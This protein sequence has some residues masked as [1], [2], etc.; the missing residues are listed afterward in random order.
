MPLLE[1]GTGG[2]TE[3]DPWIPWM[4]LGNL[5]NDDNMQLYVSEKEWPVYKY[6]LQV[7]QLL[8][9]SHHGS[10]DVKDLVTHLIPQVMKEYEK[11]YN[12]VFG[13]K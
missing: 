11:A 1:Y 9:L 8:W 13:K 7:G 10:R 3:P 5:C 4:W 2:P 12:K 6:A